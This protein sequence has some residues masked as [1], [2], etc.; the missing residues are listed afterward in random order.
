M[1]DWKT[2]ADQR[3]KE[4]T[5]KLENGIKELFSSD[6][7]KEY[8]KSMSHFHNYSSRNIMLIHQ[9][10]P[11]A[12]QVA[13]YKLW[14]EK[15][16]R[17]VKKGE[18]SLR[19]YAP[20]KGKE[21]EK[22][23]MEKLDPK[24]KEPMRDKDNNIILEEMTDVKSLTAGI[25]FKLVPVFDVSQTYGDPLP[26]LAEDLTGNVEHYEAFLDTLKAVSPLPIVFEPM[27]PEKDGYCR[28]G[29]K[30]GIREG[31]SEIQTFA[32]IVHEIAHAR[33]HDRDN[34]ATNDKPK[35]KE[36]KEIE[37]ESIS[38]VVCQKYGIETGDNSFG[39]LVSWGSHDMSEFKASLDT[40]RKESNGIISAVDERFA[41]ICKEREID[42]TAAE[43]P[44]QAEIQSSIPE[45][46]TETAYTTESTTQTIAGVDFTFEEIKPVI[47]EKVQAAEPM[48]DTTISIT[49]RN[50]YGYTYE[51]MLP[52]KYDRAI[53]LFKQDHTIF[54]LF[55]DD[56]EA[57]TFASSEIV[58][59][60]G[61]YG[62]ERDDW[63]KSK[64]YRELSEKGEK[65][66][67]VA[68]LKLNFE[69]SEAI[70]N[71][72][73]ANSKPGP[74][75]G[76][77]YIDTEK[78]ARSVIAEYGAERVAWVLAGNIK[79]AEFDGR[80]SDS[81][82]QWAKGFDITPDTFDYLKSHRTILETFVS[83]FRAIEKE[84]PSLMTALQAGEEK[85]R[86]EFGGK[87]QPEKDTLDK[88]TDTK[89]N[90]EER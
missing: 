18:E 23:L 43:Q 88:A 60:E 22:V 9:Q 86:K 15:F 33:L 24:T 64:E 74:M 73:N 79:A 25:R 29:E 46:P 67:F 54:L 19:I 50:D 30:I 21:P 90:S 31:M 63:Q 26:H 85:S 65:P 70:D 41:I 87:A 32:T 89:K 77:Q 28:F 20:M 6:K 12:T 56:T 68:S 37:A 71:A 35:S 47:P 51:H 52:L 82:K 62:I 34:A 16:N 49:D 2:E 1:A 3:T 13:S 40:I 61:I 80:F 83:K 7:Y 5:E 59:H 10:M 36:V 81:T 48:P 66:L 42:L 38:Y 17:Q 84:K 55:S 53:E 76:T 45:K 8:L 4:L 78:A 11:G 44:Q 57:M 69:C 39:Y 14:K 27:Q 72:I 58:D 75:S